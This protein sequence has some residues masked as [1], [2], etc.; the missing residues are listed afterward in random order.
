MNDEYLEARVRRLELVQARDNAETLAEVRCLRA[1]L[2]EHLKSLRE[3]LARVYTAVK[4][5][6]HEL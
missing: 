3:E 6:G 5:N 4:G 1:W 2:E